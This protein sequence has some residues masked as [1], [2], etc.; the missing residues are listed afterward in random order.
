[1]GSIGAEIVRKALTETPH[2]DS[3]TL[4]KQLYGKHKLIWNSVETVRNC[5]RRIRGAHGPESRKL[6]NRIPR[7]EIP[8]ADDPGWK[9][10]ELPSGIKRWLIISDIHAPYH[11]KKA[12]GLALE[13]G[14]HE[15]CDGVL[16]LGDLI[17]FYQLSRFD[18]DPEV[19]G[20]KGEVDITKRVLDSIEKVGAKQIIFK[21]GNHDAR[22]PKYLMQHCPDIYGTVKELCT[23]QS[24]LGL[25][26]RGIPCIHDKHTLWHRELTLIHGHEGG[27]A[28]MSPVN[29]ARGLF[30]KY[31]DNTLGAHSHQTSEHTESTMRGVDISC[32]S[33]GCLC[34]L[35]PLY[36]PIGNK[37]NHGFAV[38]NTGP[39]WSVENKKIIRERKIT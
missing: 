27:Q 28:L 30:M 6:A 33:I 7:I 3:R 9:T 22:L 17:D 14:R 39:A 8:K 15:G 24:I 19:R 34:N 4:A 38:L 26:Q 13:Y 25:A 11:S 35:R 23:L 16:I 10:H 32:Y 12:L 1:M 2:V 29:P 31:K 36:R 20:V 21:Q 5:I 18:R 37:W